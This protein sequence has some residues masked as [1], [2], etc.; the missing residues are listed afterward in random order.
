MM[1]QYNLLNQL[2]IMTN[3]L[4]HLE[5]DFLS[6]EVNHKFRYQINAITGQVHVKYNLDL[7]IKY[8]CIIEAKNKT[9]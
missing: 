8:Q 5:D 1:W 7:S 6:P 9:L 3:I 2:V 4:Y